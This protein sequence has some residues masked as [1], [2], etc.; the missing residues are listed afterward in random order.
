MARR[1]TSDGRRAGA[2]SVGRAA[3]PTSNGAPTT[4]SAA[5]PALR[6]RAHDASPPQPDE[7]VLPPARDIVG[8]A[9]WVAAS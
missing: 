8:L 5:V 1:R 9:R 4:G 3:R 2:P 6:V 7:R